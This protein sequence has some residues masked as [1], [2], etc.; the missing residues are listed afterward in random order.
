MIHPAKLIDE[1]LP[2]RWL[3][4]R[5]QNAVKDAARQDRLN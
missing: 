5:Q 2:H 4:A 1:L 3:A